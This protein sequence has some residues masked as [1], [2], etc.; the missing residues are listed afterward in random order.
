MAPEPLWSIPPRSRRDS[1]L[2]PRSPWRDVAW[3]LTAILIF[4]AF[5]AML[6]VSLR[7]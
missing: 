7:P 6:V 1:R 3:A 5:F 2:R 4:L